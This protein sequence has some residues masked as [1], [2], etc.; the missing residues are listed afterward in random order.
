MRS[1]TLNKEIVK[2]HKLQ[3]AHSHAG[4][5]DT[6]PRSHFTE[7]LVAA[8]TMPVDAK[9][10]IPQDAEG[11]ELFPEV[12]GAKFCGRAM[13]DQALKIVKLIQKMRQGEANAIETV[14]YYT[15]R[16]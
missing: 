14:E 2:F 3:S 8:L 10:Q 12:T 5:T 7:I 15:G 13:A 16:I 9:I 11:W 6:E 1:H 4:A